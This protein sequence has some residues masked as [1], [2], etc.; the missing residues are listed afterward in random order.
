MQRMDRIPLRVRRAFAL[1]SACPLV[2]TRLF[3]GVLFVWAAGGS[4][5]A[6]EFPQ[7]LVMHLAFDESPANG[8]FVDSSGHGNNGHAT[9][10][11]WTAS[12]HRGGGCAISA[13]NSFVRVVPSQPLCLTQC[14]LAVW[15]RTAR[16]NTVRR[17]LFDLHAGTGLALGIAGSERD[18]PDRNRLFASVQGRTCFAGWLDADG[19]WHHAAAAFDGR[20]LRLYVD[21]LLQTQTADGQAAACA[22]IRDI[23]IGMNL[24]SPSA[25]EQER[26]FDGTIDDAMCFNQALSE[27]KIRVVMAYAKNALTREQAARRLAELKELFD[28]GLLLRE[29]YDRKVKECEAAQ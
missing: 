9:N 29:F 26:A 3:A 18:T 21:G 8:V 5:A 4:P 10:I 14:T 2:W 13:T 7:G 15:F 17:T 24:S 25:P 23:A 1:Q 27:A 16:S 20:K 22:S 11:V 12:G 19:A 28:R 6:E